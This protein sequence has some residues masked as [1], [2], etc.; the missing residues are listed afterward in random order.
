MKPE[1]TVAGPGELFSKQRGSLAFHFPFFTA[2]NNAAI[3][4]MYNSVTFDMS[5]LHTCEITTTV[6]ITHRS[7][8]PHVPVPSS[9]LSP[10]HTARVTS[11]PGSI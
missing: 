7:L 6:K 8:T 9:P 5:I 3:F 10:P 1:N 11:Q 4:K 2:Q